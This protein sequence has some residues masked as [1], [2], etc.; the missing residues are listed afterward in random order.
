MFLAVTAAPTQSNSSLPIVD[1]GYVLQRATTFNVSV[2]CSADRD[3]FADSFLCMQ[4]TSGIYA[5]SNIRYAQPPTG[6]LRFQAPRSPQTNRTIQAGEDDRICY[7]AFPTWFITLDGATPQLLN[8]RVNSTYVDESEH[9]TSLRV[10]PPA[11]PAEDEDCLFLNVQVA[12]NTFYDKHK[13]DGAPV[14]VWIH[15]G[16]LTVGSKFLGDPTYDP[17]GLLAQSV[18]Q[19]G[20]EAVYVAL[21]YRVSLCSWHY[22]LSLLIGRSW[23]LLGGQEDQLCSLTVP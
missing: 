1:L 6:E 23:A 5:F 4:Q 17:T 11:T 16:G 8:G 21:N 13:G 3:P 20:K 19:T 2:P 15:G 9:P 18:L 14:I 12:E 22:H 10:P 7:Q